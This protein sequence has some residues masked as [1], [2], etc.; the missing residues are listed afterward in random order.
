MFGSATLDQPVPDSGLV[1]ICPSH[2]VRSMNK[3]TGVALPLFGLKIRKDDV[4]HDH[5]KR[6]FLGF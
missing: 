4:K 5:P 6:S 2:L 3:S 1:Q